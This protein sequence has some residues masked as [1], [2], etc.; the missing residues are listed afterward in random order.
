MTTV[1]FISNNFHVYLI[2]FAVGIK[3]ECGM[4]SLAT[5]CSCQHH[6]IPKE[7]ERDIPLVVLCFH[8]VQCAHSLCGS[9]TGK[10]D[11]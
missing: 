2:L 1:I 6:E 8:S 10:L 9:K 3:L 7:G 5:L 11:V 4:F